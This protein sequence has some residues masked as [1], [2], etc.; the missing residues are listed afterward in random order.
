MSESTKSPTHLGS[1][2]RARYRARLTEEFERLVKRGEQAAKEFAEKA[3]KNGFAYALRWN[4]DAALVM[5]F[6]A[7]MAAHALKLFAKVGQKWEGGYRDGQVITFDEAMVEIEADLR[8]AMAGGLG[9]SGSS[10]QL[11]NTVALAEGGAALKMLDDI[12][13]YRETSLT[14]AERD[15][16]AEDSKKLE[17][18]RSTRREAVGKRDRARS[19]SRREALDAWIAEIDIE[20]NV[21]TAE[22]DMALDAARKVGPSVPPRARMTEDGY[23]SEWALS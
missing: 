7:K 21:L 9:L 17:E 23:R 18:L 10:N 3:E 22:I 14:F 15:Y 6:Q 19:D 1:L 5:E 20:I 11:S 4:G 8:R 12:R 2:F 16:T 13:T